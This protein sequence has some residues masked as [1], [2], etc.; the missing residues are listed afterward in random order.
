MRL[1]CLRVEDECRV[2]VGKVTSEEDD[3]EHHGPVLYLGDRLKA[4]AFYKQADDFGNDQPCEGVVYPMGGNDVI[5]LMN[6]RDW[7]GVIVAHD[8]GVG[9]M[10][11]VQFVKFLVQNILEGWGDDDASKSEG[12]F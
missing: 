6:K 11:K 5:S 4:A 10:D 7:E 2:P 9:F 1:W 3:M 12:T 8:K